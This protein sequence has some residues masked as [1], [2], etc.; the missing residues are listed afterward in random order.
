MSCQGSLCGVV[1]N[2]LDCNI[3]VSEF[4][5]KSHYCVD[6]KIN[7]HGKD[8]KPSYTPSYMLNS[9]TTVQLKGWIW[10]LIPH[11]GGYDI[12]K[13]KRIT[14][15]LKIFPLQIVCLQVYIYINKN[16]H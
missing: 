8:I 16:W 12:K 3:V 2:V 10:H 5:L 13:A 14:V 11:A 6:F 15:C 1:A 7:T 9:T 4:K